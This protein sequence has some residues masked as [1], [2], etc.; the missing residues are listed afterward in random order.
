MHHPAHLKRVLHEVAK[1]GGGTRPCGGTSV[2]NRAARRGGCGYGCGCGC[3]GGVSLAQVDTTQ[4]DCA[5]VLQ[6]VRHAG[7]PEVVRGDTRGRR[8]RPW[9]TGGYSSYSPWHTGGYSSYSPW[10][11]G[12]YSCFGG[13]GGGRYSA[14]LNGGS[15]G[16]ARRS[17]RR[18]GSRCRLRQR[19]GDER[20]GS[21]RRPC[22]G[23]RW[24]RRRAGYGR[25]RQRGVVTARRRTQ[26]WSLPTST[27]H[28]STNHG[29]QATGHSPSLSRKG[30]GANGHITVHGTD[31]KRGSQLPRKKGT[32]GCMRRYSGRRAGTHTAN[33]SAG[34]AA[35]A[36]AGAAAMAGAGATRGLLLPVGGTSGARSPFMMRCDDNAVAA[37]RMACARASAAANRSA[38]RRS[39]SRRRRSACWDAAACRINQ[40]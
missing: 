19:R 17:N 6:D 26:A 3:G 11:T 12:G 36:G 1:V 32:V 2:A 15:G 20:R 4:L 18:C 21:R 13:Q 9:H 38:A 16:G 28:N 7:S 5:K 8:R 29:R 37:W 40:E 24:R 25:G 30:R 10:H 14:C 27:A 23:W 22:P 35:M 39:A 34:A 33:T 31:C